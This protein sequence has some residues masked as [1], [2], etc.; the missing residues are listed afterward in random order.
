M[1]RGFKPLVDTSD[2]N[3]MK[4]IINTNHKREEDVAMQ[5]YPLSNAIFANLKNKAAMSH[6]LDS[7]KHCLFDKHASVGL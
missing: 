2:P 5:R 7:K 6:S 3:N 1:L 4:G